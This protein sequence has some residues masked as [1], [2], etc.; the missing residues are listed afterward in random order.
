MA[1]GHRNPNATVLQNVALLNPHA[2]R[3]PK[4]DVDRAKGVAASCSEIIARCGGVPPGGKDT[5]PS[6]KKHWS[7]GKWVHT[8]DISKQYTKYCVKLPAEILEECN[9]WT[10]LEMSGDESKAGHDT[11]ERAAAY[12]QA[13]VTGAKI[14]R[15]VGV[16]CMVC[17][18]F[19]DDTEIMAEA[20]VTSCAG[21]QG[22]GDVGSGSGEG[23]DYDYDD[24]YPDD[25]DT[26]GDEEGGM[27]LPSLPILLGGGAAALLVFGGVGLWLTRPKK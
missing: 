27:G 7:K 17:N 24:D 19:W 26:G 16:D 10:N 4:I 25:P 2:R 1:R 13:Y 5:C 23:E 22:V 6:K 21:C 11:S 14:F 18:V 12:C 8:G 9:K 15:P 3:N 20:G